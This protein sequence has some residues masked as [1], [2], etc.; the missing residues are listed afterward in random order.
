M[1][2]PSERAELS[3]ILDEISWAEHQAGKPL[4]SVVVVHKG[5]PQMP[6][7]GFFDLAREFGRQKPDVDDQT[8]FLEE[9]NAVYAY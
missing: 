5:D 3:R 2:N 6:G 7:K 4:L 1:G 8:F 9:L